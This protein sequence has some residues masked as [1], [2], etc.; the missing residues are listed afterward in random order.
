MR[1]GAVEFE[2]RLDRGILP[3]DDDDPL[4]V[5]RVRLG[6]VMGDVR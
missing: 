3:A 1:T 4:A 5:I 2:R 6:V